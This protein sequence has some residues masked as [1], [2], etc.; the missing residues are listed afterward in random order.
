MPLPASYSSISARPMRISSSHFSRG[1]WSSASLVA[2]RCGASGMPRLVQQLRAVDAD[3]EH[4]LL[5]LGLHRLAVH[6]GGEAQEVDRI[7]GRHR[8]VLVRVVDPDFRHRKGDQHGHVLVGLV[9]EAIAD[10]DLLGRD[11]KVLRPH[12]DI[13]VAARRSARRSRARRWNRWRAQARRQ[14]A[15]PRP[16]SRCV[17]FMSRTSSVHWLSR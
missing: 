10:L 17:V 2:S 6:R 1:S 5:D 16:E 9:E 15:S 3:R 14:A 12:L 4:A 11:R 7:F 8:D 13:V